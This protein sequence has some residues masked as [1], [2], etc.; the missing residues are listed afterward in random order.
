MVER[1]KRATK[2]G[3]RV[4]ITVIEGVTHNGETID[5]GGPGGKKTV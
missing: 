5:E 4:V 2:R 1:L 3:S